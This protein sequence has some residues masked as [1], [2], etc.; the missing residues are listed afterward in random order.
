MEKQRPA[1]YLNI[2]LAT[3]YCAA[4]PMILLWFMSE[5]AS[6]ASRMLHL[7]RALM[8]AIRAAPAITSCTVL[9]PFV[10]TLVCGATLVATLSG[11]RGHRLKVVTTAFTIVAGLTLAASIILRDISWLFI[12][13][14]PLGV[15][16]LVSRRVQV[17]LPKH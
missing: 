17:S 11:L 16:T 13:L 9:I 8:H 14:I 3:F 10:A 15:A 5:G 12:A 1:I 6:W 2:A 7:P 4:L